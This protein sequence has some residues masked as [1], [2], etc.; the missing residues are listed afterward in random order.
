MILSVTSQLSNIH[1]FKNSKG[2]KLNIQPHTKSTYNREPKEKTLPQINCSTETSNEKE[3][4]NVAFKLYDRRGPIRNAK[5]PSKVRTHGIF[6][7]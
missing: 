7:K 5:P 2:K 4:R 1:I 6:I 3:E